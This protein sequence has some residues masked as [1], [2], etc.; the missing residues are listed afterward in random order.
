M[1]DKSQADPAALLVCVPLLS[2][3]FVSNEQN[4]NHLHHN[5]YVLKLEEVV[6]FLIKQQLLR[7]EDLAFIWESQVGYR[8][9]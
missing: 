1:D 3:P 2:L 4:R 9:F 8:A 5:Q 6:T 7:P